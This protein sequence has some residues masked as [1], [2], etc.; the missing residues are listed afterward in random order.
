MVAVAEI[1][2]LPGVP[3]TAM[4][5]RK[6]LQH[7][8]IP[9]TTIGQTFTFAP[10]DL[11]DP[12]R[13]AYVTRQIEAAGLPVGTYDEAAQDTFA[14][15]PPKMRAEA[16]R[17]AAIARLAGVCRGALTWT[18]KVALVRQRFGDDGTSETS[19]VRIERA[20][21]G[22]DPINFAPALVADY[23]LQGA[24]RAAVS[25]AAWSFFLTT[26]RDAGPQFPL[27]QAWRDVRDLKAVKGWNWPSWATIFR[28]WDS[29]PE[30][31]MRYALW[32]Q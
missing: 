4:G 25:G 10:S 1:K 24:P 17:K 22:V 15:M 6:W 11:P 29:L 18:Q 30:A 28:R 7:L 12:V 9:V 16:E 14:D 13:L 5:V 19:L 32:T 23:R 21:E 20:V 8:A 2:A 31:Q 3:Q 27:K 26:I